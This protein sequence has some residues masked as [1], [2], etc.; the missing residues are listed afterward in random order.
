MTTRPISIAEFRTL[1][2]KNKYYSRKWLNQKEGTAYIECAASN[3]L[4]S[5]KDFGF[6]LADC[7]RAV[8][9]DLS[10]HNNKGKIARVKKISLIID[11]LINLKLAIEKVE[12][13]K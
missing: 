13:N 7:H 5:Y 2:M 11:E 3:D 8:S 12:V 10:F 4:G 6:K 9:I 1:A